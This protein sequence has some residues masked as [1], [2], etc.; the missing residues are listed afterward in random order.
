MGRVSM[1]HNQNPGESIVNQ[2]V[3]IAIREGMWDYEPPVLEPGDYDST[4]A[5]PGTKEKIAALAERAE[6]GL[7]LWHDYDRVEYDEDDR[8]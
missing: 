6:M 1:L 4:K 8:G 3:L 2:N 5:M 7:P